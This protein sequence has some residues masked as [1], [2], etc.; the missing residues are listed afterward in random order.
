[1]Q[2]LNGTLTDISI[3]K[4]LS[5]LKNNQHTGVLRL[6][7]GQQRKEFRLR[8]GKP[9]SFRSNLSSEQIE[10]ILAKQG[11][12]D[13]SYLQNLRKNCR[14]NKLS[15][16]KELIIKELLSKAELQL[17]VRQSIRIALDNSLQWTSGTF[18]F[19][20]LSEK[21]L[22]KPFVVPP[23]STPDNQLP[24]STK[25]ILEED[26][27]FKKIKDQILTGQIKLPPMP[28]TMIKIRE[29]LNNPDWDNQ[30]LLRII[31]VDQLL[32]SSIL[33]TANSSF[34]GL[35]C[36]VSSLQHAIVLMGMKSIW[37]IVTHQSLL[38]SFSKKKQ[39]IQQVLDHSFLC[40]LLAR[41][42]A[43][44]YKCDEEDAFTCGLLHDIGKVVLYNLLAGSQY[45]EEIQ[46]KLVAR[47]HCETGLLI[48]AKW[49]LPELV[50]DAIEHH[51]HPEQAEDNR[52]LTEVIYIANCLAHKESPVDDILTS[53]DLNKMDF[54]MLAKRVEEFEQN[55]Q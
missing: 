36:Q 32:T 33:K 15:F 34:Y 26:K 44:T 52:K 35:S 41:Q 25:E 27:I 18:N 49:N 9:F 1:M 29:C 54:D 20:F 51:H 22:A 5:W 55:G 53:L 19:R 45:S 39:K 17:W 6:T 11:I 14:S 10:T 12:A 48:A 40:A 16:A 13:L 23:K 37:G 30:D 42:I 21:Q 43:L 46:E 31:M 7:H 4:L 38:G 47:F 24:P 28:D 50:L 2:D 3:A 8:N